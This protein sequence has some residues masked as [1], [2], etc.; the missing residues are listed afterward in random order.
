MSPKNLLLL[1]LMATLCT[2][3]GLAAAENPF[4]GRWALTLPDGRAGWLGIEE[5]NGALSGSILWGGGSVV[6]V[7]AVELE[8]DQLKVTRLHE[9][10][11]KR[12]DGTVEK[13]VKTEYIRCTLAGDELTLAQSYL[14]SQGKEGRAKKFTGKRIP[15]IPA[16]PDLAKVAFADPIALLKQDS[17][18]GWELTDPHQQSAWRVENGVL[19]NDIPQD[20][21]HKIH[22]GNLRT[23]QE[24]EDFNLTL[25]V[26][27]IKGGNSGIYLRGVYEVQ[28]QDDYGKDPTPHSMGGIYSRIQ[29]AQNATKPAGEWQ[30]MDITLLERHVTVKL[31]GVTIVDNAPLQGCTGGALWADEFRPGPIYLQG[32]HTGVQYRNILLRPVVK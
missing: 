20:N 26:N 3:T 21:D 7:D 29:P 1:T 6:P 32:D 8:G 27:V 11:K 16:T 30:Q 23:V 19:I 5:A 14:S 12:K 15:D 13:H 2:L 9:S 18:E 10:E 28:V 22:Y 24:F 25:E 17:L 31:N 4:L